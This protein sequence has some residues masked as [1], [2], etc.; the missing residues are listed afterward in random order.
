MKKKTKIDL[1]LSI[2]LL[3]YIEN[4]HKNR[5][6]FIETCIINGLSEKDKTKNN[7]NLN[8]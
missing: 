2:E 3:D 8:A 7:I 5:S 6:K 1:T 4:N